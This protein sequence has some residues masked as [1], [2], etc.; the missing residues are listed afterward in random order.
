MKACQLETSTHERRSTNRECTS[1][2]KSCRTLHKPKNDVSKPRLLLYLHV[3][4]GW[5]NLSTLCKFKQRSLDRLFQPPVLYSLT[6]IKITE[7]ES[8]PCLLL[9]LHITDVLCIY[10]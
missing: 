1:T 3:P 7:N 2:V 4:G 6:R 10:Y 8:K 5:N 9:Y